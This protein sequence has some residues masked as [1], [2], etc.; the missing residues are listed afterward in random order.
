MATG[1]SA[2]WRLSCLAACLIAATVAALALAAPGQA[3]VR[4]GVHSIDNQDK[5]SANE[6][7]RMGRGGVD[8]VRMTFD[9]RRVD[10]SNSALVADDYDELMRR[11]SA[12]GVRVLPILIADYDGK[13]GPP[14]GPPRT[15]AQVATYRQALRALASRYGRNGTFWC[16]NNPHILVGCSW[17]YRPITSW[18]VWNEPSLDYFWGGDPSPREYAALL[19]EA[20]YALEA[21]DPQAEIVLGGMPPFIRHGMDMEDF[22]RRFYDV[23]RVK[24]QFDVMTI[25]PYAASEDGVEGGLYLLRKWLSRNGDRNREVWITE[26]GWG[27]DGTRSNRKNGFVKSFSGQAKV[28][29]R[30]FRML[31]NERRRY[32]LGTV[33]WFAWQDVT[34]ASNQF[35]YNSG[36]FR[37]SGSPKPSWDAFTRF[38]GGL[39][40]GSVAISGASQSQPPPVAPPV[41][42]TPDIDTL[43]PPPDQ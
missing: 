30:T 23:R 17:N 32:N 43:E 14:I 12:S 34:N 6:I 37:K 36:L 5:L 27:T 8:T 31:E 38:T 4:F 42:P 25:H 9:P 21:G 10:T 16:R 28:L 39:D 3:K 22:L 11:T 18:Q 40:D 7:S 24:R 20:R 33:I 19:T 2:S 41:A 1:V 35:Y 29:G 15:P 26:L 13:A